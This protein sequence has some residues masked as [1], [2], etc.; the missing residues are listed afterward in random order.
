MASVRT[1]TS[2]F[3][4]AAAEA[5]QVIAVADHRRKYIGLYSMTG[6]CKVSFGEGAHATTYFTIAAGNLLEL[7][8]NPLDKVTF[9]TTGT[10]IQVIQNVNSAVVLSSDYLVLTTDGYPMT[11]TAKDQSIGGRND[12]PVFS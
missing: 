7:A 10:V 8:I 4:G 11:Y 12:V 6:N 9:S 1:T 2:R 5:E 3:N